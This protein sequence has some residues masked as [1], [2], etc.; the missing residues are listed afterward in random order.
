MYESILMQNYFSL[1]TLKNTKHENTGIFVCFRIDMHVFFLLG[2]GCL[3]CYWILPLPAYL[4]GVVF[5]VMMSSLGW[6]I[7]IWVTQ[8][9]RQRDKP[10]IVPLDKLPPFI[11]PNMKEAK[12]VDG[13]YK[14]S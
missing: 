2:I 9:P 1:T 11:L 14:V 3:I 13:V 12:F 6:K 5:G 10:E 4:S 8:P 7:Y